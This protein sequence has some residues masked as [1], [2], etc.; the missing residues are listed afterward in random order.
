MVAHQADVEAC[1]PKGGTVARI[2]SK[3]PQTTEIPKPITQREKY[4]PQML[5]FLFQARNT[6]SIVLHKIFL[7][8]FMWQ[9]GAILATYAGFS[10]T[11]FMFF[12]F[13]AV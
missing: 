13:T 3:E 9:A 5:H 4:L 1:A 6:A 2:N 8:G 12:F 10:N 11:S 7:G